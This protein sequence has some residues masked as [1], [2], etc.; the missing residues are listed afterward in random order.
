MAKYMA[1]AFVSLIFFMVSCKGKPAVNDLYDKSVY[2]PEYA[3][4]FSITGADGNESVI[5]SVTNPWQGA[6]NVMTRL[7]VARNG[8]KAPAGFDGQILNGNAKRIVTLSSSHVAMLDAIGESGAVVGVSGIGYI[9]NPDIQSRRADIGDIGYEGNID[10]EL[11]V[12]LNPDLVLLYGVNGASEM[13]GK[14]KELNIP[15]MYVGDYLEENPLGKAEWV[16]ALAELTG[17]HD[18]GI[19]AFKPVVERYNSLKEQVAAVDSVRPKVMVNTPY[20]DSWFMPSTGNYIST[21]IHDAGGE[22]VFT[23]NN[24]SSSMPI[25]LEKAYVLTSDADC[26][27]NV[28]TLNSLAE[29][30][31]LFPKFADTKPVLNGE[32]YNSTLRA[33][34]SGGNDFWESGIMNPDA[35]LNDLIK[36]FHPEAAE[37]TPFYYYKKLE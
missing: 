26:W 10:Y 1:V 13:E 33:N 30:K 5:I 28:G 21:L 24:S 11:L 20:G 27:I 6:D 8:E 18:S 7:F 9:S 2:E 34:A 19:K 23:E 36:I 4:G 3:S 22:Y 15:F 12:S 35:V 32:V 25:D 31:R 14:L 37:D 16:V 29:L 17:K